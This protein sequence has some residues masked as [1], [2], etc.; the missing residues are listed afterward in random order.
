MTSGVGDNNFD[1][2]GAITREQLAVFLY[3]AIPVSSRP[4]QN[5]LK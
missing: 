1:P 2:N 4:I 5:K 3:R